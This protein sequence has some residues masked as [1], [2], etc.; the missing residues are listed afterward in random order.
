[1]LWIIN[2]LSLQLLNM[3]VVCILLY[4]IKQVGFVLDVAHVFRHASVIVRTYFFLFLLTFLSLIK[5]AFLLRP[6]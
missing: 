6:D 5:C 2:Y 1:M 3:I 4:L